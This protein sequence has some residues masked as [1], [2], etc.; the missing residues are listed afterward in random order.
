M[1]K[2]LEYNSVYLN[3]C[4]LIDESSF[5]KSQFYKWLKGIKDRKKRK[6]KLVHEDVACSTVE[7]IK[8]YPHFS[9]SKGQAY[10]TYHQM[11]YI[12]HH[13]YK[14]LKKIVQRLIFQ[15]VSKRALL[16]ERTSY[17]HERPEKPGEIWAEDFTHIKVFGKKF[18]VSLLIDVA[19]TFY[20]GAAASNYAD[21]ELV[22]TPVKQA[23]EFNKNF[24]PKRFLLSDN[25]SQYVSSEHGELL[26]KLN[27]IQKRIPA[28]TPEYNGSCECGV[29]EFKNVF[30]NVWAEVETKETDKEKTLLSKIQLAVFES[31][32]RL[33]YELPRPSLKG[34]TPGD[35]QTG[36]N[37]CKI[38]RNLKYLEQEWQRKEVKPWSRGTWRL[39]EDTLFENGMCNL[40]LMTKFCFFLKR[41]LRKLPNLS[42]EVLGN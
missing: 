30:Y 36:I 38:E 9:G 3:R 6:P 33:N 28:C 13:V 8:K 2:R 41:P 23:L 18:Y 35:V 26:D 10:M 31:T 21:V 22:E 25:G 40:E 11:G 29:K 17:D 37:K 32:K 24:G 16:P 14:M 19:S 42:P 34:V 4:Q 15:E 27:I 12:P 7:V 20:L 5:S 1:F 39:V